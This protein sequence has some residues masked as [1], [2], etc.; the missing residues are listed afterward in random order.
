[1]MTPGLAARSMVWGGPVDLLFDTPVWIIVGAGLHGLLVFAAALQRAAVTSATALM[2]GVETLFGASVGVLLLADS[3]RPGL[4]PVSAAGFALA[5]GGAV[6][7]AGGQRAAT[8]PAPD[9]VADSSE[10]LRIALVLDTIFPTTKGGAERWFTALATELTAQGHQV[11]YVTSEG[12]VAPPDLPFVVREVVRSGRMYAGDGSR[13]LL[14][15]VRF[16]VASGWWLRRNRHLLDAVYVHQTPLF[17]VLAARLALGRRIPWAVEWIE[18]WTRDYWRAYAPGAVGRAGWMVQRAALKVT[19]RATVFARLTEARLGAARPG[20]PTD[21]LPGQLLDPRTHAVT[22]TATS[23]VPLVLVV[24]RLVPAKH[25]AAAI[26]A[27]AELARTRPVR[28]R[29]IGQGPLLAALRTAAA[30]SG[31][32]V[33]VL[34][35]VSQEVLD[36]YYREAAVLLHPSEREGF[37]LV[38]AEAAAWAVPVV[39]VAG[40]DNAAVELLEPGV[41]GYVSPSRDAGDLAAALGQVLDGGDPLRCSTAA[42]FAATAPT[43]SVSVTASALT[44]L[45]GV[46]SERARSGGRLDHDR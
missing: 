42:W 22:G 28:A 32:D 14:S 38:V 15:P 7:L 19:P 17:S 37:G 39:L 11:T 29:L 44:R 33:E 36:A 6:V 5:L 12:G 8:P 31:A 30:E 20:L 41:N 2:V 45:L 25:A 9:L 4:A 46:S 34:G 35:P 13:R 26:D 1:M 24:G 21:L 10:S 40:P 27:V 3:S 18:W 23:A 16:G 43:R